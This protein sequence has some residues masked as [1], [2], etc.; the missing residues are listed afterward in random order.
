[1]YKKDSERR[2]NYLPENE[3]WSQ[4][5]TFAYFEYSEN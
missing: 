3:N 5:W 4:I 1:M 2:N